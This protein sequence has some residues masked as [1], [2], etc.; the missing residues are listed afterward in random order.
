MHLEREREGKGK[1]QKM[2]GEGRKSRANYGLLE[3][4]PLQWSTGRNRGPLVQRTSQAASSIHKG[5]SSSMSLWELGGW[6]LLEL[7]VK[8]DFNID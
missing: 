1:L 6:D 4:H 5:M 8:M 7:N 3:K 2:R